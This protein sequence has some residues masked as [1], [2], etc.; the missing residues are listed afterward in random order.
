MSTQVQINDVIPKTQ[1]TATGGQTVFTTNWTA[2]AASDVVVYARTSAQEPDDLTQLVN[3]INYTVAFVGGSEIVEVTF[4]VA[5]SAGDVI[6]ITRDTPADRLNL[7]TNTNFTPSMLNQ[8]VGILTLVDQQAQ[9]YNE[10][11]APHYN[12]S[13]TPDLGDPM[14]GEG[15]DIY[16]PVLGANQFWYKNSSNTEI[17]AANLPTGG[18]QL[19]AS[20][21]LVTYTAT[22]YL[23]NEA[24]LGSLSTGV[25]YQTVTSG[26]ATLSSKLTTGTGNVV[27]DNSPT[28]TTPTINQI[29]DSNGNANLLINAAA[30][31]V[32]YMVSVNSATGGFTGFEVAGSDTNANA[33]IKPKGDAGFAVITSA[34]SAVPFAIYSGTTQQHVTTFNFS[35]TNVTRA[36]T[37][38]DRTASVNMGLATGG[39]QAWVNFDGTVT[40]ITITG[41]SNVTSIT[42]GGVGVYT[43]N[44]TN[45]LASATYSALATNGY[46][47]YITSAGGN[48]L[49]TTACSVDVWRRDSNNQAADANP[50]CF[51]AIL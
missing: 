7:Y 29:N 32:N 20:L 22:P 17:R 25:L 31:A 49:S 12:V 28:I 1:I 15:G 5:R 10:Q 4:L 33:Y 38:P 51:A 50:V 45:P 26:I 16:L 43:V 27:L 36:V 6:T 48:T 42:D 41:S 9:L 11:V 8:D 3:S 18:G 47:A 40:P 34:V 44:F 35:N 21:P 2:N 24:N 13:A 39:I 19:P 30:S 37:F 14:T 23:T 46:V